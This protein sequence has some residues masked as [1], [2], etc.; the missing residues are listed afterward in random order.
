MRVVGKELL[1]GLVNGLAVGVVVAVAAIL[2]GRGFVDL[3]VQSDW[4]LG[5]V[6]LLATWGNVMVAGVAGAS[7]PLGLEKLGLDPAVASSGFVT[8]LTDTVGYFLILGLASA[9]IL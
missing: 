7:I 5:L 8:A 3:G 6:A 9:I 1:V 4:T 2:V